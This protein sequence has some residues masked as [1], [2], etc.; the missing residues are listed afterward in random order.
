MGQRFS[1]WRRRRRRRGAEEQ[2]P[3]VRPVEARPS[4][5]EDEVP[6]SA[7]VGQTGGVCSPLIPSAPTHDDRSPTPSISFTR[8]ERRYSRTAPLGALDTASFNSVSGVGGWVR[9]CVCLYFVHEFVHDA[10]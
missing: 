10:T 6:L 2:H 7:G 8:E 5:G 3:A 9:A 1:S 4:A